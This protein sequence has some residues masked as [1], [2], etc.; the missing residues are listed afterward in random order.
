MKYFKYKMSYTD[1]KKITIQLIFYKTRFFNIANIC[2]FPVSILFLLLFLMVKKE[3]VIMFLICCFFHILLL[4]MLIIVSLTII[5]SNKKTINA[6][7]QNG[8]ILADIY[9]ENNNIIISNNTTGVKVCFDSDSILEIFH[10]KSFLII[11]YKDYFTKKSL[12]FRYTRE[13]VTFLTN[14]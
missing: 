13:L 11:T 14:R 1:L 4:S 12:I 2:L 7:K 10:Y 9:I 5:K 8:S 6:A 3:F